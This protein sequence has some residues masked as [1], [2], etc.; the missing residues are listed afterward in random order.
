MLAFTHNLQ[1]ILAIYKFSP[2]S[3]YC[4]FNNII[5]YFIK[6]LHLKKTLFLWFMI[7]IH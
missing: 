7:M 5:F 4:V 6:K 3:R 1:T 2:P